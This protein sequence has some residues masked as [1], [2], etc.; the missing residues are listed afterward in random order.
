MYDCYGTKLTN[1]YH[2]KPAVNEVK[3]C[4]ERSYM[5]DPKLHL[6]EHTM[7]LFDSGLTKIQTMVT[8][9]LSN[10]IYL[11]THA[12]TH[13][14]NFKQADVNGLKWIRY[15]GPNSTSLEAPK[16][17]PVLNSYARLLNDG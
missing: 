12:Y 4:H 5:N 3:K 14:H 16:D 11:H 17:D 8:Q 13:S 15:L 10:S 1:Q 2:D 6:F 7:P 9:N